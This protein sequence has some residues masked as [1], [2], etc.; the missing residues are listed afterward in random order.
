MGDY[1]KTGSSQSQGSVGVFLAGI[2]SSCAEPIVSVV[3]P[4]F[5]APASLHA[6]RC[7][8][9]GLR[10]LTIKGIEQSR[11]TLKQFIA[12]RPG[13][14]LGTRT[15][16]CT[17]Y[18]AIFAKMRF[19]KFRKASG[20]MLLRSLQPGCIRLAGEGLAPGALNRASVTMAF[21]EEVPAARSG[22]SA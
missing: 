2:S 11:R 4:Y 3:P 5:A 12:L 8:R 15:G 1:I 18:H 14:T 6:R 9:D 22:G 13:T 19:T 10:Q 20:A 16:V 7:V 21:R 17:L